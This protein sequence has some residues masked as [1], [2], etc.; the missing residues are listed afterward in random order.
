LNAA[1]ART[2]VVVVGGGFAGVTCARTL[3]RGAPGLDVVLFSRD[4]HLVFQPLLP[5]VAGSSLN[6]RAVAP[7]LRQLLPGVRCRTQEVLDVD[8]VRREV[9][10]LD[11]DGAPRRMGCDHLVLAC[12]NAVNLNLLPGMASHALPLKTIG[13]A[14]AMRARVM[15]Q[16]EM[17]D[18][19]EDAATRRFLLHFIV[20][21]GGFSGVEVAGEVNDL[22]RSVRRR[23]PGIG[24]DDAQVTLLHGLPHILP[25]VGEKLRVFARRR[26]ERRGIRVMCDARV[27]EVSARGAHLSDG[28]RVRGATVIC[29]VGTAPHALV[30]R[31]AVA[32]ERG[33]IVVDPDLR[34][35][36]HPA[37]W[38]VGDCALVANAHD[39]R[40]APPTAQFAEREG[41][42]CAR[43]ILAALADRPTRPF[44]YR[45]VGVACGIGGREGVAEL[46]GLR[47]SGFLA[48]WLWR[49]AF[50][51]KIPS[52]AQKLK[53]GIDWAW[54]LVFARDLSHFRATQSDPVARVHFAPGEVL[55]EGDRAVHDLWSIEQGEV[56]IVQR[57]A[58]GADEPLATLRAGS[59]LGAATLEGFM[60]PRLQVRARTAVDA[61]VLGADS[62][63]RL[64]S[65]LAPVEAL[66]A[67][68]VT[69]PGRSIWRHHGHAMAALATRSA[70]TLPTSM[71]LIVLPAQAPL[72]E[73]FEALIETRAGCV[74]VVE[75]GRL[76]GLATRTDLLGALARGADRSTALRAAMNA[77]PTSLDATASAA[78]AAE[79]M[80]EG[81]LKFLPL[82]DAE[83]RPVAMLCADDFV[84][85]SLALER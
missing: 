5:D 79:V 56:D 65:A 80:A 51:A 21:G 27:V 68:A 57:H 6:P 38:A 47:F 2:R 66:V 76:A 3:R 53:V 32:K 62:L 67:R 9:E 12:G 58:G 25:E 14:I 50:L 72:R 13:D 73:A 55:F 61:W 33:R 82:V 23:Y 35:A 70:G 45:P 26:M 18:L 46:F 69:L 78:R 74:A 41:R 30:A 19:A 39:G 4:N 37:A 29:T 43:N 48:W 31:L 85:L 60:D 83:S 52:L 40:P 81:G 1:G 75:G 28:S 84:R 49:S 64:S 10:Y 17:A 22:I 42:Q 63:R 16:L 7:P 36:G 54:E 20:V 44:R 77:A 71:P 59:V 15:Q 11:H 8:L 34:V 24:A